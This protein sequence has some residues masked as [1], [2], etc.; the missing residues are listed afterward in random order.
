[1]NN[2]VIVATSL[3]FMVFIALIC[4]YRSHSIFRVSARNVGR[5]SWVSQSPAAPPFDF[6]P[7]AHKDFHDCDQLFSHD[8]A[9]AGFQLSPEYYNRLPDFKAAVNKSVVHER[10]A[11]HTGILFPEYKTIHYL[12]GRPNVHNICETGFN[13][14]F[15]SF[16]YLTANR[17]AI[18]HTF[19]I[20]QHN[21]A[22]KMAAFLRNSYPNR[23]FI[24]FGDSTKTVP[25]FVQTH[26]NHR[27]DFIFVDGGHYYQAA[28]SDL[29]NMA[30]MAN[31]D[32]DNIIVFDDYPADRIFPQAG[33]A[34]ENMRR[35]GY[36]RELFRCG[37]TTKKTHYCRGVCGFVVG[38]VVR[39]P[40]FN[41]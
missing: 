3:A 27:C 16:N 38:T 40:S 30:A 26:P 13:L 28:M 33:W 32:T 1:M 36:I 41:I 18:V 35:W 12:A 19:D 15:S 8:T 6:L 21:Y 37:F 25:K 5:S 14:G 17:H 39:R 31:I 23:F 4:V 20:G 22:H 9:A 29:L 24:N 2:N 10:V 11:G 7:A 34:W